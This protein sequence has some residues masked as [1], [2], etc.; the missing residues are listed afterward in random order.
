[1]LYPSSPAKP[2]QP[3]AVILSEAKNPDEPTSSQ[4]SSLFS[5]TN[6]LRENKAELKDLHSSK[7]ATTP[8]GSQSS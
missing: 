3:K 8:T 6:Q 5:V 4:S 1:L 7:P 2:V